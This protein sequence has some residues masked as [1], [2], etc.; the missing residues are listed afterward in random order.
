MLTAVSDKYRFLASTHYTNYNPWLFAV[1]VSV[2][3]F[4]LIPKLPQVRSTNS[5]CPLSIPAGRHV[6]TASSDSFTGNGS[7]S[8]RR[9]THPAWPPPPLQVSHQASRLPA[10]RS[11]R[12]ISLNRVTSSLF[13]SMKHVTFLVT[14]KASFG[15]PRK[16]MMTPFRPRQL[17]RLY[18]TL[19]LN[20]AVHCSRLIAL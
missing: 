16:Q 5:Q 19:S 3:I 8:C 15:L 7:A 9:T 11:Q 2:L 1:N 6:L 17:I 18:P 10:S 20:T 13:P 14:P 4:V 12:L